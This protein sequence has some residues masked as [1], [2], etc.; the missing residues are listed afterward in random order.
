MCEVTFLFAWKLESESKNHGK[1]PPKL[2]HHF[3]HVKS[4][5]VKN[6]ITKYS[7]HSSVS[8]SISYTYVV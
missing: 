6:L 5:I 4:Y 2:Q 7:R 1:F 8:H 3:C